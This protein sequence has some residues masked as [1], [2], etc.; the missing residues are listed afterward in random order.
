MENFIFCV[1]QNFRIEGICL[2]WSDILKCRLWKQSRRNYSIL[3]LW[4]T[5][6]SKV[7]LYLVYFNQLARQLG[8]HYLI[9]QFIQHLINFVTTVFE[10]FPQV[11][12]SFDIFSGE[13]LDWILFHGFWFANGCLLVVS[14]FLQWA[15][16]LLLKLQ[17]LLACNQLFWQE[18]TILPTPHQMRVSQNQETEVA[19]NLSLLRTKRALVIIQIP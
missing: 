8:L 10:V 16:I 12:N 19:L 11:F 14:I 3:N 6:R 1:V 15:Q 17:N 2:K 13:Y 4:T 5:I 18:K 9:I 7:T